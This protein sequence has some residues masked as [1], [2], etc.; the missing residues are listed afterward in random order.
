MAEGAASGPYRPRATHAADYGRRGKG[1][2]FG[3]FQPAT[4][5]T[6]TRP[7]DRRTTLACAEPPESLVVSGLSRER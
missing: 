6:R 2:I 5:E 3:A 4:G 1:S 7:Y